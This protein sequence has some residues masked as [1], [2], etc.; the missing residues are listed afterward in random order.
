MS[1]DCDNFIT[2][3]SVMNSEQLQTLIA[4]ELEII[5]GIRIVKRGAKGVQASFVTA[6]R[7]DFDWLV[8]L[9]ED[10]PACWIKN[11]WV[12]KGGQAG[13]WIGSAQGVQCYRW[14]DM[15][16]DAFHDCLDPFASL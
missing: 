11:E 16:I 7:P 3:S 9:V 13:V 1:N 15:S 5:P 14:H 10:Y 6:W 8:S 2:I 4:S 12:A